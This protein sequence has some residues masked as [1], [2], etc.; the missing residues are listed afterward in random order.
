[1]GFLEALD[2]EELLLD[3]IL[4]TLGFFLKFFVFWFFQEGICSD[5][6]SEEGRDNTPGS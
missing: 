6:G 1:M 4:L 5:K 3:L 2:P